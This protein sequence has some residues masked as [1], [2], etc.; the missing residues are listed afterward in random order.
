MIVKVACYIL[1]ICELKTIK[2]LFTEGVMKKRV[3][4]PLALSSG[5]NIFRPKKLLFILL[6][7]AF[8]YFDIMV[9]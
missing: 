7:N 5:K 1:A 6:L 3:A 4:E 9:I 8:E 2:I